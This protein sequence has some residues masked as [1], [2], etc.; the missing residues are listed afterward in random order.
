MGG[1]ALDGD[2]KLQACTCV[3]G[4]GG[5]GG[6]AC[7]AGGFGWRVGDVVLHVGVGAEGWWHLVVDARYGWHLSREE[8]YSGRKLA[9]A[10]KD[11]VLGWQ[12]KLVA[13]S[14]KAVVVHRDVRDLH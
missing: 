4:V 8:T 9:E 2:G 10:G 7:E 3:G 12:A 1:E 6:A 11:E 13:A 5:G 14:E